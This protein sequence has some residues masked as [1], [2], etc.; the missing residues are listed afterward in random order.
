MEWFW[1]W[2][3][4]LWTRNACTPQLQQHLGVRRIPN[5]SSA[6]IISQNGG[7]NTQLCFIILYIHY[8]Y[9]HAIHTYIHDTYVLHKYT[10]CV[11][12]YLFR[13]N[14]KKERL[15]LFSV[16]L[17]VRNTIRR[18][19]C[20]TFSMYQSCSCLMQWT[21]IYAFMWC[22]YYNITWRVTNYDPRVVHLVYSP[23]CVCRGVQ[24]GTRIYR[25]TR[26]KYNN[27]MC[28]YTITYLKQAT[29]TPLPN[30]TCR[31]SV[32][33]VRATATA[34]AHLIRFDI[35]RKLRQYHHRH[36]LIDRTYL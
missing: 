7:S 15:T 13:I 25:N 8:T 28:Y 27:N 34:G 24:C 9:L 22:V 18:R 12:T 31:I 2:I 19:S 17:Y 11:H 30:A 3:G 21:I 10:L 4:I 5:N 36:I 26:L 16:D 14:S 29:A 32:N 35:W 1:L 6:W 23:K 20:S 33:R